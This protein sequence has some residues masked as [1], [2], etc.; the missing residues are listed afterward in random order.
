MDILA[1]SF[2]IAHRGASL[3]APENTL[4]SVRLAWEQNADAVE[5]DI[6]LSRDGR[7]MIVHDQSASRTTGFD[8]NIAQYT[9]DELRK[10]DAG[11]WKSPV[12]AGERIPFLEEVLETVPPGRKLFIEIKC[13]IE[14]LPVLKTVLPAD[15]SSFCA[16]IGFEG[17]IMA[18]AK[19]RFPDHKTC[20]LCEF[21]HRLPLNGAK[22]D[23][24]AL[25][26]LVKRLDLDGMDVRTR[27]LTQGHVQRVRDA[28]LDMYVWT[29]NKVSEAERFLSWGVQGITTDCPGLLR[30]PE[31][32]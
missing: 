30:P 1:D 24:A 28:G 3:D 7:I 16:L 8:W 21:P 6:R 5:C 19:R 18:E 29:V 10:L 23:G 9:S 25:I 32:A 14:I 20:L 15:S 4:A 22:N 31:R 26:E 12:F 17:E 27:G 11:K 13:G 2:L